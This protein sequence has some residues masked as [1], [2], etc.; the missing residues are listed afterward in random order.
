YWP[1]NDNAMT[2]Y[3]ICV[4]LIAVLALGCSKTENGGSSESEGPNVAADYS[5]LLSRTGLLSE[6]LLNANAELISKNPASSPF[7]ST[8]FPELRYRDGNTISLF[9]SKP[10]CSGE[11]T[12][13]DF[14][15]YDSKR[16]N[17]FQDLQDCDLQVNSIAHSSSAFYLAYTVPA[18]GPKETHFFIRTV[19]VGSG[20]ESFTDLELALEPEQIVIVSDKVFILSSEAE[21]EDKF[22]L[23]VLDANSGMPIHEVNLDFNVQRIF[24][25]VD[26][27]IMVSYPDLHLVINSN[28]MGIIETV[29]Y[30]EGMEPK[31]GYTEVSIFDE[32]GNLYYPMPT[33]MEETDYP[34]IPGVYD[35][36]TNT[37][38]LYFYENFLTETERDFEFKIGDT[39]M[40]SY[41][42]A[43]NLILIGYQKSDDTNKGG[44]LRVKPIPEPAFIDNIDL[45]GVPMEI[46]VK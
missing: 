44:L 42:T 40:V 11:L 20:E 15:N 30:N 2:T 29:R 41:D 46:I 34:N 27:N 32:L 4:M 6:T 7:E 3:R 39:S 45:D 25:T 28:S 26:N 19:N 18:T 38:V 14:S 5:V 13:V 9:Y 17:V 33:D 8:I 16:V 36:S 35:F 43:N 1:P 23:V 12:K 22:A 37:A 10:D 21:E 31:F 24:K